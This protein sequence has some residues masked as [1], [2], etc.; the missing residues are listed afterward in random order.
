AHDGGGFLV[1]I[2]TGSGLKEIQRGLSLFWFH[3]GQRQAFSRGL[4][5]F[6]ERNEM[7]VE[8]FPVVKLEE[9]FSLLFCCEAADKVLGGPDH[10]DAGRLLF[11]SH[12][13][14]SDQQDQQNDCQQSPSQF[15]HGSALS[16]IWRRPSSDRTIP[17]PVGAWPTFP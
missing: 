3:V 12:S 10:L 16:F 17:T 7:P 1:A 13:G 5:L 8:P 2:G 6:F 4:F 14:D 11:L 9:G 15:Y